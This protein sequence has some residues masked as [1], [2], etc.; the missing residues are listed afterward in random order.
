[1]PE[2]KVAVAVLPTVKFA[3]TQT[4]TDWLALPVTL[5]LSVAVNLAVLGCVVQVPAGSAKVSGY[6]NV[7]GLGS[8]ND[9]VPS[10]PPSV[11]VTVTLPS[12]IVG[13]TVL[14]FTGAVPV[15]EPSGV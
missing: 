14:N 9:T 11:S 15:V 8:L 2:L 6:V 10:V 7:F 4:F 5:E 13:A 3:P 1:M 12:M